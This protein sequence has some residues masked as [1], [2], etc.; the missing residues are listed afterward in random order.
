LAF[1]HAETNEATIRCWVGQYDDHK[2]LADGESVPVR[3]RA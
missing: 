1:N 3:R 2:H